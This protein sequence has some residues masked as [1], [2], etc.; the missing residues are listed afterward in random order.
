MFE[1]NISTLYS[2]FNFISHF[3]IG[4]SV[5]EI[6][7][8]FERVNH[9]KIPYVIKARRDGDIAECYADVRKAEEELGFKAKYGIQDMVRDSYQFY[10][11]SSN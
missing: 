3:C 9:I 2:K 8:A 4:Y 1:K 7:D 10:I 11:K 5:L 6:V